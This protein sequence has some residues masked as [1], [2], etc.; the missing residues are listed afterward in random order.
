MAALISVAVSFALAVPA[1]AASDNIIV[2]Y[3]G[4]GGSGNGNGNGNG[5]GWQHGR[6]HHASN[7]IGDG[8]DAIDARLVAPSGVALD[9][10]G[11]LYIA[12][13]GDN[14]VRKVA[15]D[16]VITTAVGTGQ[17]GFFGDGGQ[18]SN[19]GLRSP[20]G[21]ALDS[22][23]NLYIADTDNNR[24]RKVVNGVISTVAGTGQPGD[25]GDGG[26]ATSARLK[27]PTGVAVDAAADLFI[28]DTDNDRV[29]EVMPNGT[30]VAFAG[31]GKNGFS[32]NNGAATN[33]RL[34]DPTGVAAAGGSV[35]IA[36]TGN[37]QIR[38][39]TGGVITALAGTGQ[40]AF[41]GDGGQATGATLRRP[42]GVA[43]DPLGNLYI[44]DSD[45]SR[46]RLV[47]TSGVI[48]TFGGTGQPGF[49]GDNGPAEL[50]KT[51]PLTDPFPGAVAD[52]TNLFFADNG[53][54]RVRRIHQGGPP[55]ALP[56]APF[57]QN[58]LLAGSTVVVLGGGVLLMMRRRRKSFEWADRR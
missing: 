24:I 44:V 21:I 23:G 41:S 45:N 6:G 51:K 50:A 56:E 15:P 31:N 10:A 13:A 5:N 40:G 2:T 52:A 1:G 27:R 43:L 29:R 12:D 38:K 36:D 16:G 28:A 33:A 4:G 47:N 3:A 57:L 58:M 35:V 49:S 37:N 18:A 55:P 22:M 11:N 17:A 46:I 32:G 8:G 48:T 42:G 53:N 20:G 7:D 9:N 39:V 19:A 34:R 30:I 26:P 54:R 25:K 14:R